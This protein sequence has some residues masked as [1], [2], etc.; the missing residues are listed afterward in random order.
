[1][2]TQTK[3]KGHAASAILPFRPTSYD[4]NDF[5][6]IHSKLRVAS[7][8]WL[9]SKFQDLPSLIIVKDDEKITLEEFQS[10]VQK[11]SQGTDAKGRISSN[12]VVALYHLLTA[13]LSKPLSMTSS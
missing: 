10:C 12:D 5:Q 8:S 7:K 11:L 9:G 3:E 4:D 1:M 13:D 2:S 6:E